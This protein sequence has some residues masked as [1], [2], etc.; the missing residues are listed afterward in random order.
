M[1]RQRKPHRGIILLIV[2][3]L[4]VVFLMMGVTFLVVSG[5]Y[6]RGARAQAQYRLIGEDPRKQLD[7]AF[8]QLFRGTR[9]QGSA[10]FRHEILRDLYGNDGLRGMVI[11]AHEEDSTSQ[12]VALQHQAGTQ[13]I[14]IYFVSEVIQPF[15]AE[16]PVSFNEVRGYYAGRVLT[17]LD[18]MWAPGSGNRWG[19]PGVDDDGVNGTD[20][21]GEAGYDFSDDRL[22]F[23]H[24]WSPGRDGVWGTATGGGL[25][26][27][28]D[29]GDGVANDRW[30]AGWPGSDD[31]LLAGKGHMVH[32]GLDGAWGR[33]G[34]NDDGNGANGNPIIDDSNEAGWV[35]SDD[36][37]VPNPAHSPRIVDSGV[38]RSGTVDRYYVV[39]EAFESDFSS[40]LLPTVGARFIIN[41]GPFNGTGAG[42]DRRSP[43]QNLD[44][45]V[46]ID[47]GTDGVWGTSDGGILADGDDDNDGVA[48]EE[49]EAGWP[50]SDDITV[51]VALCPRFSAYRGMTYGAPL[52]V[53]LGGTD[54]PYDAVDPQ[55]MFLAMVPPDLTGTP[56]II[57]SFHRPALINYWMTNAPL[58]GGTSLWSSSAAFR[59]TVIMRPMPSDHPNFT[60]SNPFLAASNSDRW[61]HIRGLRVLSGGGTEPANLWD[62]DND[63]DGVPDSIWVDIGLP[64]QTTPDGR[65]YRPLIAFLVKDLDGRLNVNFHGNKAQL[66]STRYGP[67]AQVP[68]ASTGTN[69][70]FAGG[71]PRR[72]SG[73]GRGFGFGP[74]EIALGH[75]L[76]T[77]LLTGRYGNDTNPGRTAF[78]DDLLSLVKHRRIPNDYGTTISEYGSRP[79]MWGD[80]VVALDYLGQPLTAYMGESGE[81]VDNPYQVALDHVAAGNLDSLYTDAELERILRYNDLDRQQLSEG[82]RRAASTAFADA[83]IR[84][85]VTNRSSHVPVPNVNIPPDMYASVTGLAGIT[86]PSVLDLYIHRLSGFSGA[87]LDAELRKI[88]AFEMLRG[89]LFDINRPWGNGFDGDGNHVVDEP[90]ERDGIDNDS[91]GTI[92]NERFEPNGI[93]DDGNGW[94]DDAAELAT[95]EVEVVW[96]GTGTYFDGMAMNHKNNDLTAVHPRWSRQ[97]YARHL[98]CLMMAIRDDSVSIFHDGIGSDS[99]QTARAIAQWAINVVDF[100]DP[101]SIMTPFEYDVDPFDGWMVSIDGN[102]ASDE[103]GDRRLVWGCERPELLISETIA[104]H[105]RRTEDLDDPQKKIAEPE[106][107]GINDYDQ[108]LRPHGSFFAEIYN[109]WTGTAAQ[110]A[111]A[112][113]YYEHN[114]PGMTT[115]GWRS[116]VL[117]NKIN[118]GGSPVWRMIVVKNPRAAGGGGGGGPPPM[119]PPIFQ[120]PPLPPPPGGGGGGLPPQAQDPD[121]GLLPGDV[122]RSIY[123]VNS[124]DVRLTNLPT[125]ANSGHGT[126]FFTTAPVA[127]LRPGRYAVVG[128]AGRRIGGTYTSMIGRRTT[129]IEGS[130][131]SL[132]VS[133]TRRIEIRPVNDATVHQVEV[134]NNGTTPTT[135]AIHPV[136]GIVI[137]S[138]RS[139]SVSEPVSGYTGANWDPLLAGNEGA[140]SPPRDEPL[141]KQFQVGEWDAFL[142]KNETSTNYCVVHLQRL[143][144]PLLAWHKD[145]NPFR[146]IDSS[147]VDIT[148]FN[149]VTPDADDPDSTDDKVRLATL[150]RGSSGAANPR[151]FRALWSDEPISGPVL[152]NQVT[153]AGMPLPHHF[154]YVLNHSLGYVNDGYLNPSQIAARRYYTGPVGTGTAPAA[155]YIGAPDTSTPIPQPL[156]SPPLPPD[157]PFPWLT[158]N[159]RP[160]V[161]PLE[162]MLVPRSRS[163]RL[164]RNDFSLAG[165]GTESYDMPTSPFNHLL[166]FFHSKGS[167]VNK[168][169]QLHRIFDFL[170]VP[171]PYLGTE[172]WYNPIHFSSMNSGSVADML[173]PPFNKLSRFR[174]PGRI[175]INTIFDGEIW[176][177][178]AKGFPSMDTTTFAAAVAE[179]RQGYTGSGLDSSYPTRFA[180]P[181]RPA[182]SA[183]LSPLPSLRKTGNDVNLLRSA[184]GSTPLFSFASTDQYRNTERNPF[185]R[186]RG[187]QRLANMLT[188]QSN[189]F[190]VWITVGYFEVE[191]NP[192]G[193]D[194]AHPEGYRLSREVGIDTGQIK[195]HR[196][197]YL[198]DRSIPVAFE[199]GENHNVDQAIL[200]RRFIE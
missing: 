121:F 15:S 187:M 59:S 38:D 127:P 6:Q 26:N 123:F 149:G 11:R 93:D 45:V 200:I 44:A 115:A 48:N 33:A 18:S 155:I 126:P 114:P 95:A 107:D 169:T 102:P 91:D 69:G 152:A 120:P 20:D 109:P 110:K 125:G 80:G 130:D 34:V 117:L 42:F 72:L 27:G 132:E 105:D 81:R 74:A 101:D 53:S 49:D 31:R 28:D 17:I 148:A 177:G 199:P 183:H 97:I 30:E 10:I 70:F 106:E 39:V 54:E 175:N 134:K 136:V 188:N 55:N 22:T 140:Y 1:V 182:T 194:A 66:L 77:S 111:P 165:A 195:R 196:G 51:P 113:F 84:A 19:A 36:V 85:L 13:F 166:N 23:G 79:D 96:R 160:F 141:D 147:S 89:Q 171:S 170:E 16:R 181:F 150:Q 21:A 198:I 35:G 4:L 32:P 186:Y 103:G 64:L 88:V 12:R 178:I 122:D 87:A 50:G 124:S 41:G 82:L 128:S 7:A 90:F 61:Y 104:L 167:G 108:R 184:G 71:P 156:P 173:R 65:M 193:V 163:S 43:R 179:S 47:R 168:A 14:R 2:L 189:V 3:S 5:Q 40:R 159:N 92:D 86:S 129:A 46:A 37:Y 162:M 144:N 185:F 164:L 76:P 143:A 157:D 98:Y 197:F 145:S 58:V 118:Q 67:T 139:F 153:E 190:A 158:W 52:S 135:P 8:M 172:K 78:P 99:E 60:G 73:L 9:D 29:N 138:P 154:P 174:D 146:T 137:N 116:G 142:S 191:P 63:G 25:G 133:S 83:K 57:P 161:T 151:E 94:V 100:R 192:G 119:P 24:R 112:E 62:V 131:A 68:H 176:E 56:V 180:N 75:V